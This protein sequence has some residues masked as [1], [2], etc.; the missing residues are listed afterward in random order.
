MAEF[1]SGQTMALSWIGTWGTLTLNA[2]YRTCTWTPSVD[3]YD[4]TAG[5]DT[6][7]ARIAGM[8]DATCS[9]TMVNPSGGTAYYTN[10]DAGKG[11]T[12][13]IQPEGTA[14]GKRKI[15]YPCWSNGA[16]YEHP[17]NDVATVSCTFTANG[18]YTDSVN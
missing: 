6:V 10:L 1:I 8:K 4:G 9:I 11:G 13:I 16:Q 14:T 12:L 7:K 5:A 15:T 3:F 17:Y 18:A 2:D